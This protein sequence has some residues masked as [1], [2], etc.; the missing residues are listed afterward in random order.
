MD[1]DDDGNTLMKSEFLFD[2][3]ALLVQKFDALDYLWV[4]ASVHVS[5]E[6]VKD[7]DFALEEDCGIEMA[8]DV[9][10][11]DYCFRLVC[12][13]E[14]FLEIF[15]EVI[16]VRVKAAVE[17]SMAFEGLLFADPFLL[18]ELHVFH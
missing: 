2:E 4:V 6:S 8:E 16:G 1:Y 15:L 5:T 12:V 10:S 14:H 18:L 7:V 9:C 3:V 13:P 17:E 11:D